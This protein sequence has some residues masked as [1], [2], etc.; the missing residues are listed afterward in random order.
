MYH[1]KQRATRCNIRECIVH[2][3]SLLFTHQIHRK[4]AHRTVHPNNQSKLMIFQMIYI[5]IL[6]H[7]NSRIPQHNVAKIISNHYHPS[8]LPSTHIHSC[9]TIQDP[10]QLT[11]HILLTKKR[12]HST[13]PSR[14]HHHRGT[15]SIIIYS[16]CSI[17]T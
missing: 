10:I 12:F 2:T 6:I 14:Q 5:F 7:C 11:E 1:T 13:S 8:S 3:H 15:Y 16:L 9:H 17:I 4:P